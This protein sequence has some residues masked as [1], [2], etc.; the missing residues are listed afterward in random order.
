M[1]LAKISLPRKLSKQGYKEVARWL[2]KQ[3]TYIRAQGLKKNLSNN[4]TARYI[5]T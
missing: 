4:F 5:G 3:A 1:T 2:H